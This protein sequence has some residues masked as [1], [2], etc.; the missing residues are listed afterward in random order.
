MQVKF[1]KFLEE[2]F[3]SQG[4]KDLTKGTMV[5]KSVGEKSTLAVFTIW[6]NNAIEACR[7]LRGG[8]IVSVLFDIRSREWNNNGVTKYF[9]DAVAYSVG[10]I[11]GAQPARQ[12]QATQQQSFQ[13]QPTVQPQPV[14]DEGDLP[15]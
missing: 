6:N 2:D 5:C 8:E 14:P 7:Q 12:Q 4:G 11:E 10:P 3:K 9:T 1:E 13:P 15:F